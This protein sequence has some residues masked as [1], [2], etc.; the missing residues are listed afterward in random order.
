MH[1]ARD[2]RESFG[3]RRRRWSSARSPARLLVALASLVLSPGVRAAVLDVPGA[4]PGI[5]QAVDAAMP[6]DVIRVGSGIYPEHVR[7]RDAKA[8]ITIEAA[9]PHD[10]P[11]I[12]GTTHKSVDGI[13][14]DDVPGVVLR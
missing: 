6:D 14:V 11:V 12:L 7:I 13:R 3:C 8:G 4:Y 9:N 1:R 2:L 10:P 5:Q